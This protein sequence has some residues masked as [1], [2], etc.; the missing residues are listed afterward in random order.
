VTVVAEAAAEVGVAAA[1]P[2]ADARGTGENYRMSR[3]AAILT[4]LVLAAV[5]ASPA[6]AQSVRAPFDADRP[7]LKRY[8]VVIGNS[9]YAR[10]PDLPNAGADARLVAGFLAEN[11][12]EVLEHHDLSKRDFEQVLRRAL[13]DLDEDS[14]VVLFYAGHGIQIGGGNYLIPVDAALTNAYDVPFEAVSLSSVIKILAARARL[15]MIIL[16]ACRDNPFADV[17]VITDLAGTLTE[18]R[19]GFN[20]L[21]API[22][23]L[24]AFSTSPGEVAFD[25]TD[26]NSPFTAALIEAARAEP[27]RPAAQ[28]FERVRRLVWERTDGKQVPWESSTLVEPVAFRARPAEAAPGQGGGTGPARA[29]RLVSAAEAAPAPAAADAAADLVL[30]ARLEPEVAIGAALQAAIVSDADPVAILERPSQGHLV[31]MGPDGRRIDAGGSTIA[32]GLLAELAYASALVDTPAA[33]ASSPA[34]TDRL[35]L[36]AAGEE[37]GVRI[38]LEADPCDIEAGDLLDPE[39]VGLTRYPNEIAPEAALAA[40]TAAVAAFSETGR[41]HYQLGRA[42]LALRQFDAAR[43]A[44]ERARELGHTRAYYALGNLIAN[45]EAITAGR[46]DAPLPPGAIALYLQG[47]ERG[48]PYAMHALG[49]DLLRHGQTEEARREGFE[50]LSR[51]L[52]LGHTF[53][54]NELGA[55]FINPDAPHS[56]PPRGLRY[57]QESADRGDIYG[58]NN[59]G[60]A[61]RDGLAGLTPDPRAAAEW[62]TRA[63][64]GGHPD[65]PGNLGRL[66]NSGALGEAGRYT[67]AVEWYDLGLERG[68]GWGGAN[69][70]WIILNRDVPG[71]GPRD[72][73]LRAA[74]AAALRG[75]DSAVEARGLLADLP[76]AALDAAAQMLVDELGGDLAVDGAFGP[77]SAAEMARV[78]GPER[79]AAVPADPAGRAIALAAAYWQQGRF[80]VDLY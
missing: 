28:L 65:A 15:Q 10:A 27:D 37:I 18:T 48:D 6:T 13:R 32:P 73:A 34:V 72:A 17:R 55:Y 41:F 53:S 61:H 62:F 35:R 3:S 4:A 63:A 31:V 11:G 58:Y 77:G 50:L 57:W 21:T 38:A 14:E 23:S 44:Y 22:N 1:V 79:A 42:H 7:V 49:R 39:G 52:E 74:K 19:D 43:A 25:G 54:M 76:P 47:V 46:A 9:D 70:A 5:G 36:A 29:L 56:D 20:A 30:T 71:L 66:W 40:C 24:L 16:D 60:V 12:F 67:R 64:E 68:D 8:A 78:L 33:Q 59:L 80:R 2:G 26:G 75:A 69:A 51:A 45:A